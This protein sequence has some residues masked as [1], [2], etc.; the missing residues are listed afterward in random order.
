M[1]QIVSNNEISIIIQART[2]STRL[3]NKM[4]KPFYEDKSL[5]EIIISRL[6][7]VGILIIVATTTND[8]DNSIQQIALSQNVNVFKGDE[9]DVLSRFIEAAKKFNVK[10]I[11]RVCADNPLLDIEGLVNLKDSFIKSEVDYW[12]YSTNEN[13]PTIK[14]HYGFWAEGVTLDT[15]IK[16]QNHTTE[17]IYREHVTNY[18]YSHADQFSIHFEHIHPNIEKN[19][20]RLTID[21]QQDFE[22]IK[23]I[24]SEL[25]NDNIKLNALEI[26]TYVTNKPNWL[27]IMEKEIHLNSK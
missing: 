27:K 8:N 1:K 11:I 19:K 25:I 6:K 15:L 23:T 22:L 13:L 17:K 9:N 4:I 20:V 7:E 12:C 21:T 24:Y 2:G 18:I 5:L 26:S 16:V 14:T 10:K 3:P